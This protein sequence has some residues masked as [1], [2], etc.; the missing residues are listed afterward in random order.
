MTESGRPADAAPGVKFLRYADGRAVY[1]VGSGSYRF[2][3][4]IR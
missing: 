3:S 4:S 1:T 2:R